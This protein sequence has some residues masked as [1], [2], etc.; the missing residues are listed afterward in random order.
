VVG[1]VAGLGLGIAL[2]FLRPN[3]ATEPT[4]I[5]AIAPPERPELFSV[6]VPESFAVLLAAE[7]FH[8]ECGLE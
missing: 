3:P 5:P 2:L 7:G 1:S 6:V 8:A 4:T